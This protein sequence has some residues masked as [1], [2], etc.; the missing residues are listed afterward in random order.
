MKRE[1][2]AAGLIVV[3]CLI[4]SASWSATVL[5]DEE[6]QTIVGRAK[7]PLCFND[8]WP[9]MQVCF[10]S[11]SGETGPCNSRC[12]EDEECPNVYA[13]QCTNED[14]ATI[15][16]T[17]TGWYGK[18]SVCP[19]FNNPCSCIFSGFCGF[20]GI[21]QPSEGMCGRYP[22]IDPTRPCPQN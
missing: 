10:E 21:M 6:M 22:N 13:Y 9:P 16:Q 1:L 15:V 17:P 7:C 2:W 11:R 12:S 3:G 20:W 4:A 18:S 14:Y 8:A 5:S 19:Q